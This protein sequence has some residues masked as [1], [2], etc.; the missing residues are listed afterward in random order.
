[1]TT[2]SEQLK[3][4]INNARLAFIAKTERC[5]CET[6]SSSAYYSRLVY[7]EE[8]LE[9]HKAKKAAD[10]QAYLKKETPEEYKARKEQQAQRKV[11][12]ETPAEYAARTEYMKKKEKVELEAE[13]QRLFDKAEMQRL[14]HENYLDRQEKKYNRWLESEEIRVKNEEWQNSKE[15]RARQAEI[16][17]W[18]T[19]E[20]KAIRKQS[21]IDQ[22]KMAK[23]DREARYR[24]TWTQDLDEH[25]GSFFVFDR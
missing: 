15:G 3:L 24:G 6:T 21:L 22:K 18:N 10:L 25:D 17:Y 5:G 9:A 19:P 7:E 11:K 14:K 2:S 23:S 20:G 1:M 13:T 16:D 12:K 4:A 8:V